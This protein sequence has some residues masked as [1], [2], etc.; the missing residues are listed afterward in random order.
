[1]MIEPNNPV[2]Q[3]SRYNCVT[4]GENIGRTKSLLVY[5]KKYSG[6]YARRIITGGVGRNLP[7]EAPQAFANAGV[8]VDGY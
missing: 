3:G 8:E 6:R 5:A 2:N 7:Q 4:T 1:M